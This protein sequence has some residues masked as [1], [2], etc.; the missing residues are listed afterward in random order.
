[1][2]VIAQLINWNKA[3]YRQDPLIGIQAFIKNGVRPSLIPVLIS[4]FQVSLNTLNLGII[5][6]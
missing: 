3:F 4:Y 6:H 1:M 2:A 5:L